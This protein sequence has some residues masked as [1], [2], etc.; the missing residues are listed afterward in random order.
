MRPLT[1]LGIAFVVGVLIWSIPGFLRAQEVPVAWSASYDD[2]VLVRSGNAQNPVYP[3]LT[4]FE[5]L[6]SMRF[7]AV[8]A[9]VAA[10]SGLYL[11]LRRLN[12]DVGTIAV[13]LGLFA[14]S[15]L[16]LFLFTVPTALTFAVASALLAAGCVLSDRR[17]ERGIG[18]LLTGVAASMGVVPSLHVLVITVGLAL[19]RRRY[20][21]AALQG[22]VVVAAAM[23]WWMAAAVPASFW[24]FPLAGVLTEF[25]SRPGVGVMEWIIAAIGAGWLWRCRSKPAAVCW[26]LVFVYASMSV[27][28]AAF[29]VGLWPALGAIALVGLFNKEWRF[30]MLKSLSIIAVC[31]G[32][33]FSLLSMTMAIRHAPPTPTLMAGIATLHGDDRVLTHPDVAAWVR[34]GSSASVVFGPHLSAEEE[35][36]RDAFLASVWYNRDL[37]NVTRALDAAGVTAVVVTRDMRAGQVWWREEEGLLFL[38]DN[39]EKFRKEFANS[40]MEIYRRR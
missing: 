26:S 22:G 18:L 29:A 20:W 19:W 38:L 34:F 8:I 12:F 33:L 21:Q 5:T 3:L 14:V 6:S 30:D 4:P 40:E 11:V 17:W 36:A 13:A 24:T 27:P 1:V 9:G 28:G 15:T 2:A 37:A 10:L 35:A 39:S 23:T 32:L 7:A 31:C 16:S 25:G